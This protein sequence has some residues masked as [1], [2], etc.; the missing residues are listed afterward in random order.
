MVK[1]SEEKKETAEG[2]KDILNVWVSNS[3][4]FLKMWGDTNLNLYKPWIDFIGEKSLKM[5][6]ISM[7]ITPEKY[8]EF[9]DDWMKT[10]KSVYGKIYPVQISSPK[11]VLESFVNCADESN[12]VYM[13]W[14]DEFREN[15]KKTAEVLNDGVDPAK[16]IECFDGWL[17]TYEKVFDDM[18][19]H[20]AIKYQREI[21]TNYTG[22]PDFYSESIARSA[23]L[24]KEYT[25]LYVPS[26]ETME[27]FSEIIAKISKGEENPQAYKEFYDLSM[28]SYKEAFSRMF[29]PQTM[30]PSKELL[31]NLKESTDITINL[32]KSCTAALEKM[33]EKMHDQSKL[34]NDP[35][36]FKEFYNL[37]MKMYEKTSEDIFEGVPLVSPMKEMIE[38]VKNACKIYAGTSIKMSKMWM[39][40]FA[41]TAK[42]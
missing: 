18:N 19:D 21:F 10:Y 3:N 26:E 5:S 1:K 23:K 12:K 42:A 40:S 11:E 36:T 25:N 37:W 27:K 31:D 4:E 28:N 39:D 9:Y 38:P 2:M 32:F 35:E 17:K 20:P 16:Y 34:A 15:S 13:S 7:D 41:R 33:S 8:K 14:M 30:K 24:M 22:I 6:D 29:D